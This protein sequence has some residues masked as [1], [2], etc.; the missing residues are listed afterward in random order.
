VQKC[1]SVR[2]TCSFIDR[3]GSH[4]GFFHA[5]SFHSVCFGARAESEWCGGA[6]SSRGRAG[7]A[8]GPLHLHSIQSIA[9]LPNKGKD[10]AR[11]MSFKGANRC[12]GHGSKY[13]KMV[14]WLALYSAWPG[15]MDP[16]RRE[17]TKTRYRR[18]HRLERGA[19]CI[20]EEI[21]AQCILKA[22]TI[23]LLKRKDLSLLY[24]R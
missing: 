5:S 15:P 3:L 11:K 18:R 7:T 16:T 12:A 8:G 20:L 24:M 10:M 23:R 9:L 19:Q 2:A 14:P 17:V 13:S 22:L 4:S 1:A 6:S 21:G